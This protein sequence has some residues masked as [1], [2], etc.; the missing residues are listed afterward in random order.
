MIVDICVVIIVRCILI[1]RLERHRLILN[2][3]DVLHQN[4]RH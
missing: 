4:A 3:A 2:D 1:V